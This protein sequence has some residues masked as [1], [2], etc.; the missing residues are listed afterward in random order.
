MA[1]KKKLDVPEPKRGGIYGTGKL[2]WL[3]STEPLNA[4]QLADHTR[5]LAE[6]V[7]KVRDEKSEKKAKYREPAFQRADEL[8]L[9]H[10]GLSATSIARTIL[11]EKKISGLPGLDRLARAIQKHFKEAA[12]K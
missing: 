9:K 7:Q 5:A 3:N 2:S 10:R 4:R 12:P 6:V 1:K 8:R 11:G